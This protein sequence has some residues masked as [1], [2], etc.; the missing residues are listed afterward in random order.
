[1]KNIIKEYYFEIIILFIAI[2]LMI[3]NYNKAYI[4][5]KMALNNFKSLLLV[6]I[7][8]AFLIGYISEIMSKET[9]KKY[10]GKESGFKG[11]II[12]AIFGTLMVGPAYLFY[13]F[14]KELMNKEARVNVI[15]TSIGAWAIKLQWL[16]FAIVI[17]G[18]KFIITLNIFIFIYAIISGFIVEYFVKYKFWNDKN[19]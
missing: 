3:F 7:S 15:A 1:M 5:I 2:I 11:V 8:V 16:P 13:P 17:L 14:F 10:V 4:S 18:A 19:F 6:I 9:I 12:G